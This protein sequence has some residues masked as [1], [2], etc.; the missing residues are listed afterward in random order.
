MKIDQFKAM[1]ELQ[2]LR[3]FSGQGNQSSSTSTDLMENFQELLASFAQPSEKGSI[4]K[5]FNPTSLPVFPSTMSTALVPKANP[6]AVPIKGGKIDDV[7]AE[8]ARK[9]RIDEKLIRSVIQQ[10]SN[11][12]PTA[13]SHAGAMG[14][15][16]LMPATARSLGV[17]N[18]FDAAQN[19]EGGT[20]YLKQMMTKYNN[21]VSLALA[22]YNAGPGN[23]DKYG[24]IPPFKET[25][26]Y[27]KKITN[28]YFG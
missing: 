4:N 2:A 28:S 14:L 27:V 5:T 1:L 23:V 17:S 19:V 3:N 7:I 15:M 20:K 11:F 6:D 10:E 21:D 22:S 25:Q 8:A 13:K 12:N 24:G 9:Y 18:P 16:Q 26:N